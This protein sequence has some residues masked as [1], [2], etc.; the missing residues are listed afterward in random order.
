MS[1]NPCWTGIRRMPPLSPIKWCD[2]WRHG[3]I[4]STDPRRGVSFHHFQSGLWNLCAYPY[5]K[6]DSLEA[7]PLASLR[8][9]RG[10]FGCSLNARFRS[11]IMSRLPSYARGD[12]EVFPYWK[13]RFIWQNR[14]YYQENKRWI[15]PWLPSIME[16]P[17][18]LQK[19]EWNCKGGVRDIWK[20]IIQFRASECG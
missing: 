2:A 10:S 7:A 16:F 6:Y 14:R 1:I 8:N 3:R 18:S 17:P 15:D 9:S 11:D 20:Y 5:T 4:F 12:G 19:F 13:Q